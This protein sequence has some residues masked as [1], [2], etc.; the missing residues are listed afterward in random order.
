MLQ[1]ARKNAKYLLI[2]HMKTA[3]S[4]L[5]MLTLFVFSRNFSVSPL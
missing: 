5:L 1:M 4:M 2:K 3:I